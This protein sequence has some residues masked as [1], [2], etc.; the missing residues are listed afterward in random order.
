[1]LIALLGESLA[2]P[3]VLRA[4]W[5]VYEPRCD[6]GSSLSAA[7]HSLVAARLGLVD[8]AYTYWKSAAAVD[9]E[10]NKGNTAHG[11]HA[12]SSGGIWQALVFGF[13]GLA[14]RDGDLTLDPHLPAHWHS[15]TFKVVQRGLLHTITL[16]PEGAHIHPAPA[17]QH[18]SP[19][20]PDG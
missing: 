16:R 17:M 9:L 8:Q 5:D 1:M 11:I 12:A 19:Q 10:D 4:N 20:S 13:A 15:M 6:H 2:V 18:A 7:M 3:E 14:L